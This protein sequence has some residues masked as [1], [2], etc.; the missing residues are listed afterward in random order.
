MNQVLILYAG[1]HGFLDQYPVNKIGAYESHLHVFLDKKYGDFM[2]RLRAAGQLTNELA[3]EAEKVLQDF[4][5]VFNLSF[6][7]DTIDEGFLA[8]ISK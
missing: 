6:N 3:A 5:T 1:T 4:A 2:T 7:G 8:T